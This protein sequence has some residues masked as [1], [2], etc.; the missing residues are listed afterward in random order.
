MEIINRKKFAKTAL[1]KHVEAFV[2]HM[3]FLLTMA[4]HPARKAQIVL[5]VAKKVQIL[6]KYL[7]FLYV[8]SK[9]K[10]LILSET[11]KLNQHA[12]KLHKDE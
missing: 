11:T 10:A 8:F 12:I 6:S 3:T 9:K 7:D 4:I 2:V 5:L 1:D